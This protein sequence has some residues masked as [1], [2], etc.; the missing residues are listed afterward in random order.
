MCGHT[1]EYF[2][3]VAQTYLSGCL[4]A[5]SFL[6]FWDLQIPGSLLLSEIESDECEMSYVLIGQLS[7]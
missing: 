4:L 1:A 6:W 2:F 3:Q 5:I 7:L